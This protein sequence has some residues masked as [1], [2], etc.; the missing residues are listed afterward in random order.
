M[1]REG[2]RE[3]HTKE[4]G[5]FRGGQHRQL[6]QQPPSSSPSLPKAAGTSRLGPQLEGRAQF[7]KT[8][9]LTFSPV[10]LIL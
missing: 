10:G 4:G 2:H 3:T 9:T 7:N 6:L 1:A 8:I 5:W